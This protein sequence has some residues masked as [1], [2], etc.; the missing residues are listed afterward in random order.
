LAA[1]DEK[2]SFNR[3][4]SKPQ[5]STMTP[6]SIGV[7]SASLGLLVAAVRKVLSADHKRKMPNTRDE[8]GH[9]FAVSI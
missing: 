1:T 8:G 6:E 3:L 9:S 7:G 2:M 4:S 5:L